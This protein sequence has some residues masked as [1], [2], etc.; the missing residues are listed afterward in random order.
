MA[1]TAAVQSMY[2]SDRVTTTPER[3]ITMLFDRLVRDLIAAEDAIERQD[4]AASNKELVHAQQIL[5]ELVTALDTSK[6]SGAAQLAELYLYSIRELITANV[7]QNGRT[8]RE[9]RDLLEPLGETWHHAAA[10]VAQQHVRPQAGSSGGT[11]GA[12]I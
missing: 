11:M 2:A 12:A 8:V 9:I 7:D 3:L 5:F 6:W 1:R 10:V 4:R